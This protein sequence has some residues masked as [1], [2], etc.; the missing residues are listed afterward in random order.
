MKILIIHGPNLSMLGKRDPVKYGNITMQEINL[1]LMKIAKKSFCELDFFQS[2][3]EGAIID[4]LQKESSRKA[5]GVL[6]NP[7]ALVRYGYSLRQALIDFDKP[8]IEVHMTDINK[9]GVNI[10]VN[11]LEDIRTGQTSGLREKSYYNALEKLVSHLNKIGN[12]KK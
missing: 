2:N 8:F 4:F 7:G 5:N 1:Q 6:I 10:S 3:H 11:V 9:T 12:L